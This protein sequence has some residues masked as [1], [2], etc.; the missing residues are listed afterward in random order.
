MIAAPRTVLVEDGRLEGA[1]RRFL[2]SLQ[3]ENLAARS[4]D[5]RTHRTRNE[6]ARLKAQ[7]ATRRRNSKARGRED[8]RGKY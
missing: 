7:A 2:R 5:T 3:G 4:A 8:R 1:L 6:R